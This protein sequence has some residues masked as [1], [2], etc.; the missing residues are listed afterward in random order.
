MSTKV[1]NN[2]NGFFQYYNRIYWNITGLQ[3]NISLQTTESIIIENKIND[4]IQS[5]LTN[6]SDTKSNEIVQ[7][8]H[9][10]YLNH[11]HGADNGYIHCIAE[12]IVGKSKDSTLMKISCK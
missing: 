4:S 11:A 10:L 6:Q 1:F 12:N 3:S 7:I 5:N 9:T 2:S 8:T